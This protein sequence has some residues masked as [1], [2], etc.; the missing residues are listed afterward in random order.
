MKKVF[1]IYYKPESLPELDTAFEPLDNSNN[2]NPQLYEWPVWK[3]QYESCCQQGLDYWGFVSWKFH[4][5]T[6][7]TGQKFLDFVDAN[8]GYDIYFVNPCIVS[9]SMYPN[10]WIQCDQYNTKTADIGN[11]FLARLG[12]K[13][14]DVRQMVMDKNHTFYANYFIA[15]RKF[16]DKYIAFSQAIFD[17][18]EQDSDFNYRVFKEPF[19]Y[20]GSSVAPHFTF[21]N[22]RLVPTLLMLEGFKCLPYQ[23]TINSV[24]EKYRPYFVEL[25]VLSKLK[26]LTN[27]YKSLEI[28]AIWHHYRH[29]FLKDNPGILNLE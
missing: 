12:Y 19:G 10:S 24:G 22:E 20:A 15:N 7:I 26:L 27:Q 16:W 9:E 23:Y 5:K 6:N 13:N 8:P 1:Q 28:Y 14:I 11:D 29:K 21:L 25:E 2:P 17:I 3:S 4:Q 18:A